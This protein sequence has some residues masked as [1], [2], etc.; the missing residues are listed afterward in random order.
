MTSFL[1]HCC[2]SHLIKEMTPWA[3]GSLCIQKGRESSVIC[4]QRGKAD[5][6]ETGKMRV[7]SK[8]SRVPQF[9]GPVHRLRNFKPPLLTSHHSWAAS[10]LAA[11]KVIEFIYTQ[12]SSQWK[13]R[14]AYIPFASS[15]FPH[16]NSSS[17]IP[18]VRYYSWPKTIQNG[19]HPEISL[20]M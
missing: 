11:L 18:L 15:I 8:G 1:F 2:Q 17:Q 5:V 3:F 14:V 10:G 4:C 19:C 6:L 13:R 20:D 16:N 7:V 12:I 9:S